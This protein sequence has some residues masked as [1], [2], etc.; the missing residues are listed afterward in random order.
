MK[1]IIIAAIAFFTLGFMD[2]NATSTTT[3]LGLALPAFGT[4]RWD[5]PM[6]ANSQLIDSLVA[7]KAATQTFVGANLFTSTGNVYHGDGSLLSGVATS[8]Q[9]TST[10]AALSSEITRA[11]A[12]ENA[13]GASTG[14]I[15]TSLSA[16]ILSTAALVPYV[17]ATSDLQMGAKNITGSG[18]VEANIF[19]TKNEDF[20]KSVTAD[21]SV[22]LGQIDTGARGS[23]YATLIGYDAG[24]LVIGAYN[25]A[26]GSY[27]G[28][29]IYSGQKNTFIGAFSG[30]TI[31]TG[32]NNIAIGYGADVPSDS[33]NQLNIGG[34][35]SGTMVLGS[36]LTFVPAISS[37]KFYGDG[38]GLT[39]TGGVTVSTFTIDLH[40]GGDVFIASGTFAPS[41]GMVYVAD[42][43]TMTIT[44]VKC[45]VVFPGTTAFITAFNIATTTDTIAG[46][47]TRAL[48]WH[49]LMDANVVVSTTTMYTDWL[50]PNSTYRSVTQLPTAFSLH[51]TDVPTGTAT[52]T[53]PAEY[54]CILRYWRRLDL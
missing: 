53:M 42:Y 25:T 54:G 7:V 47:P 6:N 23:S 36:T 46:T 52:G 31:Y 30:G 50:T 17:G 1:K 41:L 51:T 40:S 27:A 12:R 13:I 32:S 16:V 39:G 45:Y 24:A 4:Y 20:L 48:S 35:I 38:S 33:S 37:P 15:Q 3:V 18:T 44:G 21:A 26:V 22:Y 14:T 8:A 28:Q 29:H 34:A 19:R 9:L 10:A 43:A 49:Y 5:L 2:G 11:T